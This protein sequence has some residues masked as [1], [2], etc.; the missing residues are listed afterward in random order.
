MINFFNFFNFSPYSLPSSDG[1]ISPHRKGCCC[2]KRSEYNDSEHPFIVV[3]PTRVDDVLRE[4]VIFQP[5]CSLAKRSTKLLNNAFPGDFHHSVNGAEG[6]LCP[7]MGMN[8][9]PRSCLGRLVLYGIRSSH[10]DKSRVGGAKQPAEYY[11]WLFGGK[12]LRIRQR[13]PAYMFTYKTCNR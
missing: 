3:E 5:K 1:D 11:W 13:G 2:T 10:G 4:G 12:R 6:V 7:H 8:E 9:E